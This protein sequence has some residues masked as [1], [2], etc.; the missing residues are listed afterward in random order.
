M[1]NRF[2][3]RA[4]PLATFF[5]LATSLQLLLALAGCQSSDGLP[6]TVSAR[7]TLLT[8]AGEPLQVAG[9]DVGTGMVTL[10]F[11][12]VAAPAEGSQTY[13]TTADAQGGFELP[14]GL[15]AGNYRVAVRQWEPYPATD[16]LRG[17]YDEQ[18]TPLQVEVTG[19]GPLK[20][21]VE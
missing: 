1:T 16:K 21:V 5:A 14:G 6:A 18:N 7:G 2:V 19:Q 4:I 12:P 9:R 15:P 8:K 10:T 3:S 13:A 17:K 11:I 20:I